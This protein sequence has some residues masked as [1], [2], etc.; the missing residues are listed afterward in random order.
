MGYTGN[1]QTERRIKAPFPFYYCEINVRVYP[2]KPR[3]YFDA[4]PKPKKKTD[5]DS[6]IKI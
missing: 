3:P 4:I 2:N 5:E 1:I 6:D